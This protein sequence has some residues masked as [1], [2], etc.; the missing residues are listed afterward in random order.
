MANEISK[1]NSEELK[2]LCR[3]VGKIETAID[4]VNDNMVDLKKTLDRI[5][6]VIIGDEQFMQKGMVEK[7]ENMYEFFEKY[8]SDER[9]QTVDRMIE[10][11]ERYSW[12]VGRVKIVLL[13]I[14]GGTLIGWAELVAKIW[15]FING[16]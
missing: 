15:R 3:R 10:S 16:G 14:G 11:F 4:E 12:L 8:H 13:F 6:N 5:L 9:N 1:Q 7:V 2:S